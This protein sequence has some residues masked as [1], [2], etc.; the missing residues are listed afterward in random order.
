LSGVF[1][2]LPEPNTNYTGRF[3]MKL[4]L[5]QKT[6]ILRYTLKGFKDEK[7]LSVI[8]FKLTQSSLS[9][10]RTYGIIPKRKAVMS[11]LIRNALS[12]VLSIKEEL[13]EEETSLNFL[14]RILNGCGVLS[15]TLGSW[16]NDRM[17]RFLIQNGISVPKSSVQVIDLSFESASDL[18]AFFEYDQSLF[19]VE[20]VLPVI[21]INALPPP[22][23]FKAKD[24]FKEK[25]LAGI[26]MAL[27]EGPSTVAEVTSYLN[28]NGYRNK[29]GKVF[30]RWSVTL[31][32]QEFGLEV[33]EKVSSLDLKDLILDWIKTRPLLEK[34]DKAGVFKKLFEYVNEDQLL[35]Y[36]EELYKEVY[37]SVTVHNRNRLDHLLGEEFRDK[38]EFAVYEKYKHKPITAVEIGLELGLHPVHGN[39]V[40]RKYL[41]IEPF[42]IW[43]ENLY[44]LVLAFIKANPTFKIETLA[45]Y[46]SSSYISTQRGCVK[47]DYGNTNLTYK[48]LQERYPDLPN[49]LGKR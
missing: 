15:P 32:M 33:K 24:L 34:I 35:M 2:P 30:G 16:T 42:D 29:S 46:L 4:T 17:K 37:G 6:E 48:K 38:V 22:P 11:F 36:K 26:H 31:F 21:R 28:A 23:S 44:N 47:W 45:T 14:S 7:I 43:F 3:R 41:G 9:N 19:D 20:E 18:G 25:L 8:S 5:P 1:F 40:M 12:Q 27:K 10:L 39:R 49:S 13:G